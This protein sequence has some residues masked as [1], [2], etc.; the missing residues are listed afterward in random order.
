MPPGSVCFGNLFS[1]NLSFSS[2]HHLC[3]DRFVLNAFCSGSFAKW[4]SQSKELLLYLSS[5]S[6]NDM[7]QLQH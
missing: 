5:I 7:R 1:V 2:K 6:F 4:L 3:F